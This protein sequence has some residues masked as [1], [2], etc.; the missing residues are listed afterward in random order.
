MGSTARVYGVQRSRLRELRTPQRQLSLSLRSLGGSSAA[1]AQWQ[2]L[3]LSLPSPF[4]PLASFLAPV[5]VYVRSHAQ[6]H[7]RDSIPEETCSQ[8]WARSASAPL[9]SLRLP[10]SHLQRL[11]AT[12]RLSTQQQQQP[13]AAQLRQSARRVFSPTHPPA[14]FPLLPFLSSL[15]FLGLRP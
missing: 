11:A 15:R 3:Q 9:R 12:E 10:S 13:A 1:A 6:E 8:F 4:F 2:R 14:F 5:D 7:S